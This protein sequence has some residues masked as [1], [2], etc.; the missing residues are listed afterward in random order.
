MPLNAP[1]PPR[2]RLGSVVARLAKSTFSAWSPAVATGLVMIS[3]MLDGTVTRGRA[4][5]QNVARRPGQR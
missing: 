3:T 5:K 2:F 1:V 4:L